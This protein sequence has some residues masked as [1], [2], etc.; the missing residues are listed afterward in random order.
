MCQL[1]SEKV[2]SAAKVFSFT[3]K[4]TLKHTTKVPHLWMYA[5]LI[6][7]SSS[8]EIDFKQRNE[9]SLLQKSTVGAHRR[10]P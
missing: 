3:D 1:T 7:T 8:E 4:Q 2:A 6:C 10:S 9:K 5:S